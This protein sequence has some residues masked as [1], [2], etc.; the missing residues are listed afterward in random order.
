MS[1]SHPSRS[2]LFECLSTLSLP[3]CRS[4]APLSLQ[5]GSMLSFM[6]S[7]AGSEPHD[8]TVNP[9]THN[10]PTVCSHTHWAYGRKGAGEGEVVDGLGGAWVWLGVGVGGGGGGVNR[11]SAFQCLSIQNQNPVEKKNL[12]LN[13]MS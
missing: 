1:V 12:K 7:P 4:L 13:L 9:H 5:T 6:S 2:L 3:L 11:Y 10:E 8:C